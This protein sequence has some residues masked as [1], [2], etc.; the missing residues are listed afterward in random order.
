MT[1]PAN[2]PTDDSTRVQE[3]GKCSKD[4][5]RLTNHVKDIAIMMTRLEGHLFN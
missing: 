1:D 5:R 2:L 3:L 4:L